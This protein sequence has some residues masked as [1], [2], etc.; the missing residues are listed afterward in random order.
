MTTPRA[1]LL[2]RFIIINLHV[3]TPPV[4]LFRGNSSFF[5]F[6]RSS[7]YRRRKLRVARLS[8]SISGAVHRL[9]EMSRFIS[10]QMQKSP[11]MLTS[12]NADY[13]FRYDRVPPATRDRRYV[14]RSICDWRKHTIRSNLRNY[15]S[16]VSSVVSLPNL[17][18]Y[19]KSKL[20]KIKFKDF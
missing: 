14:F 3:P 9:Q 12:R 13:D 5:F 6:L 15:K 17:M 16:K 19:W 1:R 20:K 10:P 2:S 7:N 4:R 18:D 8:Q 11:L